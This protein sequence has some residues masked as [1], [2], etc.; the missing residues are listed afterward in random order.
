[1]A[2]EWVG[3]VH[4]HAGFFWLQNWNLHNIKQVICIYPHKNIILPKLSPNL[5][6]AIDVRQKEACC[7]CSLLSASDTTLRVGD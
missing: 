2:V 1:M 3:G 7:I 5:C 6:T 4:V